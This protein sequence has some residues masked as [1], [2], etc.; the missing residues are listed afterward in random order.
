MK[1]SSFPI[2]TKSTTV[3]TKYL[4]ELIVMKKVRTN[5]K[6]MINLLKYVLEPEKIV[7]FQDIIWIQVLKSKRMRKVDWFTVGIEI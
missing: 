4:P 7:E 3:V 6:I 1:I 2:L 5:E